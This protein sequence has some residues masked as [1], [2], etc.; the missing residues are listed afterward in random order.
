M[1]GEPR[2]GSMYK[3]CNCPEFFLWP[4]KYDNIRIFA[5]RAG[6]NRWGQQ[7]RNSNF[8]LIKHK[9][10]LSTFTS[11]GQ[12]KPPIY[13]NGAFLCATE[14][15]RRRGEKRKK[16]ILRIFSQYFRIKVFEYLKFLFPFKCPSV[17]RRVFIQ[18]SKVQFKLQNTL[19]LHWNDITSQLRNCLNEMEISL[20]IEPPFKYL[21]P[22]FTQNST[23]TC[24]VL[25]FPHSCG[26]CVFY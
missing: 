16:H 14:R 20:S 23:L 3:I 24:T 11:K 8:P 2:Q 9:S 6:E 19:Q 21:T 17:R 25:H 15:E 7:L 26:P 5:G 18:Y 1:W 4:P 10:Q 12:L 22:L 13:Y